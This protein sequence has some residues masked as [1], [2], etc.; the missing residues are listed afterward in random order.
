MGR[1]CDICGHEESRFV[2]LSCGSS[3][4][5]GCFVPAEWLCTECNSK[6]G[7][8]HEAE[9]HIG[10]RQA[11]WP[12]EIRW[13]MVSFFMVLVGTML[14]MLSAG[15][16]ST[17]GGPLIFIGPIPIAIGQG[18]GPSLMLL[19]ILVVFLLVALWFWKLRR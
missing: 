12:R 18:G 7:H 16:G 3:V 19:S 14:M 11:E 6:E 8:G 17:S 15:Y 4:C 10:V 9:D 1:I 5:K 13:F 2:C